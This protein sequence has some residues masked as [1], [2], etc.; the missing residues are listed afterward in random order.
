MNER[1]PESDSENDDDRESRAMRALLKRSLS[2]EVL[3]KDAPDLLRGVQRRIR[4]R[5]RGK[6]FADG[7]STT[8]Q[9]RMGYVLVALVTLLLAAI[10]YY[11]LG[12][13]DVR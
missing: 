11:A 13:M 6:F 12:P 7:W 10:A 2:T 4:R 1:P 9:S 3:A 5:S 8:G